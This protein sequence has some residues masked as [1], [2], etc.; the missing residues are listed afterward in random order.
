[1]I[2]RRPYAFL[3]KHFRFIHLIIFSMLLYIT[4]KAR[5]ILNFLKDY[6][7]FNGNIEVISSNYI[8]YYMFISIFIIII[9]SVVIFYLMKYKNK[10]RL[11]YIGTII[12]SM[13]SF[14]LFIYLY[15]SIRSLEVL[16]ISGR[17]IRLYRDL[18]RINYWLLVITSIPMLIRGLGFD[19]K[20]FNFTNDL[21]ELNLNKE[22]SAEVEVGTNIN[23]NN[24]KRVGRRTFREL[25]YY[26]KDNKMIINIIAIITL[27]IIIMLFPFN[28]YVVNRDLNEGEILSNNYFNLKVNKSY[29]SDRKRISKNNCYVILDI[30]VLGKVNKYALDLDEFVL[31][32]D[33][34]KYIPSQKYYNYFT[35]IGI[36]YKDYYLDINEYKN[37]ILI[38]N[39]NNI[40]KDSDFK[41]EYLNSNKLIDLNVQ[42]L[43]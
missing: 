17:E 42:V 11:F 32:G 5:D 36:G 22:D 15:N 26:Y 39:I 1:M 7:S 13:I 33:N 41:L 38:Y 21:K 16:T 27:F 31:I 9:L 28:K 18:S 25:K 4:L 29:I 14:I 2:L 30:S 23:S 20:K 43:D 35:D 34:N 10:P 19:I 6:I 3:I 37:Y 24:I 8:N 12:V 40:D